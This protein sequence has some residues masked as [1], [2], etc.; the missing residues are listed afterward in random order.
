MK[1]APLLTACL[2]AFSVKAIAATITFGTDDFLV[3]TDASSFTVSSQSADSL[4]ISGSA[5]TDLFGSLVTATDLSSVS[6]D[7]STTATLTASL[8]TSSSAS[9]VIEL[10]DADGD[11]VKYSG[12]WADFTNTFTPVTL[13]LIG[14][15]LNGGGNF[16]GIVTSMALYGGGGVTSLNITLG[17]LALSAVPEPAAAA[18][19]TGTLILGVAVSRRRLHRRA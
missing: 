3:D 6:F 7:S 19:L 13:T 12:N 1:Y 5:Q 16:D 4:T 15:D 8:T 14:Y 9:F 10:F 2:L 11:G 17:S 18:A